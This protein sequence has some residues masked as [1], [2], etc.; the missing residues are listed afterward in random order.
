MFGREGGS[1]SKNKLDQWLDQL[2]YTQHEVI[3]FLYY[4]WSQGLT[5]CGFISV[6]S[7][8]HHN[9]R[10][11]HTGCI[12][13]GGGNTLKI[14]LPDWALLFSHRMKPFCFSGSI[15]LNF[16]IINK[17]I[18]QWLCETDVIPPT[19][20][21][22]TANTDKFIISVSQHQVLLDQWHTNSVLSDKVKLL[23]KSLELLK[24]PHPLK[25]VQNW[26]CFSSSVRNPNTP[27]PSEHPVK[28]LS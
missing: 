19:A 15:F 11:A 14:K 26:P 18:N 7:R 28:T 9:S 1:W 2:C 8:F 21:T 20:A 3:R 10:S 6:A 5:V 13:W 16:C 24:E 23:L 27:K 12:H 17:M 25:Y 4:Q 22:S